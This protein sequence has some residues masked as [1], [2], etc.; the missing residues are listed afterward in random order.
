[1]PPAR[2][3]RVALPY[4]FGRMSDKRQDRWCLDK[5]KEVYQFMTEEWQLSAP[6][7][8]L[9]VTGDAAMTKDLRPKFK[10]NLN[11]SL[12]VVLKKTAAWTFTGGTDGGVMKLFGELKKTKQ[13]VM[14]MI[15]V[16][17]WGV[18]EG[19]DG[20][21][22]GAFWHEGDFHSMG[23]LFHAL[24]LVIP[25]R[26]ELVEAVLD[27]FENVPED[28]RQEL[29][30]LTKSL[31]GDDSFGD[32]LFED[33]EDEYVALEDGYAFLSRFI[34][35]RKVGHATYKNKTP[36]KKTLKQPMHTKLDAN[37]THYI[38]VDDGGEGFGAE[39]KL[40]IALEDYISR[41]AYTARYDVA[42]AAA[43]DADAAA[44][45]AADAV[46]SIPP[47]P[48]VRTR[49]AT[50]A[51]DA[52]AD[53]ADADAADAAAADAAAAAAAATATSIPDVSP[54]TRQKKG[55]S[56]DAIPK[57]RRAR[58]ASEAASADKGQGLE[59]QHN[60]ICRKT[61]SEGS[62]LPPP[63]FRVNDRVRIIKQGAHIGVEV[64][65]FVMRY[66][67][68]GV[69]GGC[70][71]HALCPHFIVRLYAP[72]PS[73]YAQGVHRPFTHHTQCTHRAL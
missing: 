63:I 16:A 26:M 48:S 10:E 30:K 28:L 19:R 56:V 22:K 3:M 70:L 1:M 35:E 11:D 21:E 39:I 50:D 17:T 54:S 47:S 25:H 32:P 12:T 9:S 66:A 7:L 60:H 41:N 36:D 5:A 44:D 14:P 13:F 38:L 8:I 72:T 23:E 20:I 45:A 6:S 15:G 34:Q 51:A 27:G 52:D 46:N 62:L 58:T 40:R 18:L 42:T 71:C 57:I 61:M 59:D 4:N 31:D 43:T 73:Q 68:I 65:V 37:H 55:A 24:A 67:H 33:A 29:L 69:V 49:N 2:I 53:A 64:G